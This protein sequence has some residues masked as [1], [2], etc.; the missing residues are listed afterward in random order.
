MPDRIIITMDPEALYDINIDNNGDALPEI[1]FRFHFTNTNQNLTVPVDGVNVAVP[2]V[3]I[4][5][6][7][8][9]EHVRIRM[10]SKPIRSKRSRR[11]GKKSKTK[12]AFL[13]NA[14]NGSTTFTK[15]TDN[16]GNKTF[17]SPAEYE[18][19]ADQYIYNVKHPELRYSGQTI[20]RSAQRSVR[21][22]PRRDFRSCQH[23]QSG[24]S[25]Q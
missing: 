20:C 22:E 10:W 11:R 12:S 15:P 18:T 7:G 4:G 3:N 14:A 19:Y 6:I 5:P 13:T 24:W 8:V 2:L 9:G 21:S 23:F 16:I 1:T 25:S 17:G